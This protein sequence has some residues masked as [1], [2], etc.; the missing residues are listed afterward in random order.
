MSTNDT[1]IENIYKGALVYTD[2]ESLA[3]AI[4]LIYTIKPGHIFRSPHYPCT[5]I[6]SRFVLEDEAKGLCVDNIQGVIFDVVEAG[7]D[8]IHYIGSCLTSIAVFC[9][10]VVPEKH[11]KRMTEEEFEKKK[12]E[13]IPAIISLGKASMDEAAKRNLVREVEG[14]KKV[15]WK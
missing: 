6:F 10:F 5:F 1:A 3:K 14:L 7:P 4:S 15:V 12:K 2:Q 13:E 11:T 9:S 8:E